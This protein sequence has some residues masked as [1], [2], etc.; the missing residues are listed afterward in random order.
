[1]SNP[2]EKKKMGGES[3]AGINQYRKTDIMTASKETILLMMYAGAIRFL[4]QAQDF[5]EKKDNPERNRCI[6]RAQ[7]IINE[8]RSSLNFDLGGEIAQSL[9]GLYAYLT[10]TLSEAMLDNKHENIVEAVKLLNTLNEGWE[11]AAE[12]QKKERARAAETEK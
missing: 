11:H 3:P 5:S 8:L 12:Q 2:Y 1:M 4:K 7:D 6:M 10:K 9:D